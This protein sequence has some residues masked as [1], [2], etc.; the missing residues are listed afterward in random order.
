M[1]LARTAGLVLALGL[2]LGLLYVPWRIDSDHYFAVI[3]ISDLLVF[4]RRIA[5]VGHTSSF[6]RGL[7]IGVNT[8]RCFPFLRGDTRGN[9][10][11]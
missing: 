2:G 10:G 6:F 11:V 9:T 4:F 8:W 7:V 3:V 1:S 5:G